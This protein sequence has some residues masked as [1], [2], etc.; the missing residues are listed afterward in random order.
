ME[1]RV[2]AQRVLEGHTLADKLFEP[3]ALH[4]ERPLYQGVLPRQPGR[5]KALS[6]SSTDTKSP[7]A[8]VPQDDR[9][10]GVLLHAFANHEL[11]AIELMALALLRFGDAPAAFRRGLVQ[12]LREEQTHLRLYA[13]RMRAVG[14]ELGEA[15]CSGFFWRVMAPIDDPQAF[16]AHM[17]LTFEQANLDFASHYARAF[18]QAGDHETAA[19]LQTVLE[20]EIGHVGFGLRWF[21][22]WADP[23]KPLFEAHDESL[24]A[25]L[26]MVRAKGIGF[27][28]EPRIRAGLSPEYIEQ[29]RL[30]GGSRGRAAGVWWFNGT[31]EH[32]VQ[33]G[34]S[35]TAPRTTALGMR[36]LE[37]LPALLARAHDI[38]L[39]R[40]P[41]RPEFVA[42]L[43]EAGIAPTRFEAADLDRVPWAAPRE[44]GALGELRPWGVSPR[45]HAFAKTARGRM[46]PDTADATW[47]PEFVALYDKRTAATLSTQL[48]A[49]TAHDTFVVQDEAAFAAAVD[50]IE[51]RGFEAA[52]IK[53]AIGS[54]GRGQRRIETR[55]GPNADD[56]RFVR[57]QLAR[58]VVIVEPFFEVVAQLSARLWAESD[59]VRVLDVGRCVSDVRGQFDHAIIGRLDT[60][61][62]THV[63]RWL[64]DDGRD[65]SKIK[66]W[67][68]SVARC[69]EERTCAVGYRGPLGVDALLV[70]D[71]DTL[72]LRPMVDLNPRFTMG[73]VARA[74]A[75]HIGPRSVGVWKAMHVREAKDL[76]HASLL[77]WAAEARERAP[78]Q[79][80][81]GRITQGVLHTTDPERAR[82]LVMTLSVERSVEAALNAVRVR[83]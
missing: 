36:D 41:P 75:S 24:R 40:D 20:D 69:I 76:G 45:T 46:R 47:K 23:T 3:P 59:R 64:V 39:V 68:Q 71:G 1:V 83:R 8:R 33:Q 72:R 43:A 13:E 19:V 52:L 44:L 70:G 77:D 14:V 55:G 11:L 31:A 58:G 80:D 42:S 78:L 38:V 65:P 62:P 60:G 51:A 30:H 22:R 61:L 81:G 21:E 79:I 5:D 12:T 73:H 37:T 16:V 66:R 32:E 6:M 10:R 7:S 63:R 35:Y 48:D 2:F 25:P 18:A 82:A 4:D 67:A 74:L 27:E 50:S 26:Q 28:V 29:L 15:P 49:C 34:L 53:P 54:S 17:A 56:L 57:G 9:Q